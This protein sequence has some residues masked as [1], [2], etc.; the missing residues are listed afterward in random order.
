VTGLRLSGL[1]FLFATIAC[2]A[3]DAHPATVADGG[4]S[5]VTSPMGDAAPSDS[6]REAGAAHNAGALTSGGQVS[7]SPHYR[8][9]AT[10]GQM[11]GTGPRASSQSYRIYGGVVGSSNK[12]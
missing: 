12:P 10:L 4:A 2:G 1:A 5:D 11:P 3:D 9:V 8:I 6:A 7:V